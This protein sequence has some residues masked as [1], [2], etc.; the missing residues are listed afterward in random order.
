[1]P[2]QSLWALPMKPRHRNCLSLDICRFTGLNE[3]AQAHARTAVTGMV[4]QIASDLGIRWRAELHSDRG[5]GL[6]IVTKCGI[7][8]LVTDF[9]RQLGDAVRRHNLAVAPDLQIRLRLALDAGYLHKDKKGYS[10]D[11]LIRVARLL[12]AP[13]FKEK[14]REQGAEF[15]VIISAQLHEAIQ[16]FHLLDDRKIEKVQVD[17]KETHTTAWMWIP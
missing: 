16:G 12:D 9:P 17:V 10:G 1:M 7:E 14:M 13:E 4:E 11:A 3:A 5:D 2:P 8:V 15:A 6:A